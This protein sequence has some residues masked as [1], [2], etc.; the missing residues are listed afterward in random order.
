MGVTADAYRIA[1][2]PPKVLF[3]SILTVVVAVSY[4]NVLLIF[5]FVYDFAEVDEYSA[6][7]DS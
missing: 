7:C 5:L 1:E 6:N 4:G 2:A 3:L